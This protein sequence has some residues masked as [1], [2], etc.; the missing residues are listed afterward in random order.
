MREVFAGVDQALDDMPERRRE[1]FLE[2]RQDGL[3]YR[4]VAERRGISAETVHR[5]VGQAMSD[6]RIALGRFADADA[7][8]DDD[9][10]KIRSWYKVTRTDD[11]PETDDD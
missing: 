11:E 1:V 6:L 9:Q 2:A 4:E 7:D 10:W 3:S 5:H 8:D